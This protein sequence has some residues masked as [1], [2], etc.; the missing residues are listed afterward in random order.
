MKIYDCTRKIFPEMAVF[1]G[2]MPPKQ[3]WIRTTADG[4]PCNLSGVEMGSH[5]G[6]HVDSPFHFVHDGKKLD[7]MSLDYFCG[8]CRVVEFPQELDRILKIT[9]GVMRSLITLNA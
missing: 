4:A 7:D 1:P 9:D 2:D 5:T 6:T 3:T 8:K